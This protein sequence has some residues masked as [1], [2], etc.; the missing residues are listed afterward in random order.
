MAV[1][2]R[3]GAEVPGGARFCPA[4]AAPVAAERPTEERKLATVLFADLTGSM[5]LAEQVDA[6]RRL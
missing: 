5:D 3:C 1:C 4:C 2:G 6:E